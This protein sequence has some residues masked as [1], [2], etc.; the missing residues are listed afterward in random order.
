MNQGFRSYWYQDHLRDFKK[1]AGFPQKVSENIEEICFAEW[2][3]TR[4][5]HQA[6][7][8]NSKSIASHPHALS[9]KG[10]A[11]GPRQKSPQRKKPAR[12]LNARATNTCI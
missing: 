10:A 9:E 4:S 1:S 11:G 6:V 7:P 8:E 5:A 3:I 12:V 2:T